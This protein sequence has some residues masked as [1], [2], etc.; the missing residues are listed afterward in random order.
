MKPNEAIKWKPSS[1]KLKK[2]F[3]LSLPKTLPFVVSCPYE[4]QHILAF[5]VFFF[6]RPSTEIKDI[7]PFSSLP[8][9]IPLKNY[10]GYSGSTF[11][12]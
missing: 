9:I 3:S 10:G 6:Y 8:V 1:A 11:G 2:Q 4:Y 12:G 7:S 5:L